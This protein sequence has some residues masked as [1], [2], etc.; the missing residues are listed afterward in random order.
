MDWE[1][2]LLTNVVACVGI[3]WSLPSLDAN[4]QVVLIEQA[5]AVLKG[6]Q[7]TETCSVRR[8][9]ASQV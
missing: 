4:D 3:V 7:P 6:D 1:G 2:Q 5:M 9:A 8:I